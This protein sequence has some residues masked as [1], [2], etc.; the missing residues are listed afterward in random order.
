V[1]YGK[2]LR[3][4]PLSQAENPAATTFVDAIDVVYDNTIPYNLRFFQSLDC[5][6][7]YEPWLERDK[8]MIEMPRSIG[9]EKGKAFDP[10][11]KTKDVLTDAIV[12]AHAYLDSRYATVFEPPFDTS[13]RWALP[14]SKELLEGLQSNYAPPDA[15]PIEARGLAF[16]YAYFSAKHLGAGQYYL[17]T[18]KDK[19]G[20]AF[21][22]AASYR[23]RVPPNPPVK[24]YWSATVYDR[25]T[26]ALIRDMKWSSRSS[27][28]PGLEKN[29]DGST[30][31]YFGPAAPHG[32]ESN[33]V[34][35]TARGGFEVLFRLYGP[36]PAF[37]E[38]KWLLPDVERL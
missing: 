21:D 20:H 32:K 14:A 15:Y 8:A 26:H 25:T 12:E 36:E 27:N 24:L 38:K 5:M 16:S 3:V 13:A 2:R 1:A 29:A 7:Q 18:I 35:T 11:A 19:E 17:M 10:D 30:D 28:T 34:P 22:G 33:W 6:V 31:V 9:I 23:L 4:Y 37:F